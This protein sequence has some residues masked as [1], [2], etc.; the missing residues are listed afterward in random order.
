M[1]AR[2]GWRKLVVV[3]AAC[4]GGGHG[5]VD[6]T[7]TADVGTLVPDAPPVV[8]GNRDRLLATY[9]AFLKTTPV[10]Q[11]NGLL[12]SELPDVCTLWSKLDPS[13]RATFLTVTARLQGSLLASDG[14]PM[15]DH[16]TK[17]Y[18]AV[19]GDG[20]TATDPGSCGGGEANRLI[21]QM[22]ADLHKE[23]ARANT[24]HGMTGGQIDIHDIPAGGFW[25]DSH[26]LGG[27]HA[28][29]DLSDETEGGAPRGQVQYFADPA[30]TVANTALGRQDLTTLV[31][32]LALEMDEDFDCAH[33]SNPACN[34][35]LYGALCAPE[36]NLQ[37][38]AIYQQTYGDYGPGFVPH[39]C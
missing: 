8:L 23:L 13:S 22:D 18:R 4:G 32:P 36:A 25:R 24:D 14:S 7:P 28:P 39:G 12:G 16:V 34:Y 29:F 11:R 1:L 17:L 2:M 27:P 38:T 33:N 15:L 6:A 35:T 10:R 20:A 9:L 5:A 3:L 31:D 26:D 19:G 30:S 21:M 37:G